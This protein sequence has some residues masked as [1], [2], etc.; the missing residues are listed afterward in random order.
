MWSNK[1]NAVSH[2][3]FPSWLRKS[4]GPLLLMAGTTVGVMC[5]WYIITQTSGSV[6]EFGASLAADPLAVLAAIADKCRPNAEAGKM[7]VVFGIIQALLMKYCPGPECGFCFALLCLPLLRFAWL[8]LARGR[9]GR[10]LLSHGEGRERE[11]GPRAK[12][13]NVPPGSISPRHPRSH[14]SPLQQ[15][16]ARSR[17]AETSQCTRPTVSAYTR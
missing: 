16:R 11:A 1:T 15:S 6:V 7:L 4:I 12:A 14:P 13:R 3:L 8:C 9:V 10:D 5:I 2:G 17:P